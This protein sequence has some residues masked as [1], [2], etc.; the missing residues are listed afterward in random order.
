MTKKK[1]LQA[2]RAAA[3]VLFVAAAILRYIISRVRNARTA[4]SPITVIRVL[5]MWR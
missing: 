2:I 1:I 4:D 5:P 3:I